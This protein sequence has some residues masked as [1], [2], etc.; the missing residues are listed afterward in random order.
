M[1]SIT[2]WLLGLNNVASVDSVDVSLSAPWARNNPFWL[3]LSLVVVVALA[4]VFYVRFQQRGALWQRV[5]LGTWRG[6]LLAVLL[7]TLAAPV[8]RLSQTTVQRPY[9][10]VVIDGTD[11]MAIEDELPETQRD[12]LLSA[13]GYQPAAQ[14]QAEDAGAP[15]S[16][17]DFVRQFLSRPSGNVLDRLQRDKQVRV[18][19]FLFDGQSTSQ[20]RKLERSA[21]DNEELEPAHLA[22]Q[23]SADG[24]V[25]AMG[26]V[27]ADIGRQF[28]A[29]NLA[30]VLVVSDFANNSGPAPVGLASGGQSPAGRLG[31]PVYTLGVGAREAIDLAIDLQTDPKMKKAERSNLTVK[32][33]Q[34]GLTDSQV[35]VRLVARPLSGE[36]LS[37]S[38]SLV[39]GEKSVTL[40]SPV[41]IVDFPFTP[42]DSGRFE[43][44]AEV[45]PVE[46][47]AVD[48]N[49]RAIRQVNI[50]DDYLRLM[51]IEEE[52]SWEWRFVKEVFHRDKLVGLDG[53]RT[54]L[55]SSDARVRESNVL[56]LPTLT[57]KRSQ[58]FANDV[59]FVG[60]M[61]GAMLSP[62]FCEMAK[63]FVGKF[64]GG[65]VVIAGPRFG[66]RELHA[67]ALADLLPVIVDP[68]A[69]LHDD[70]P[71]RMRLTPHAARYSFMHLG[72]N[73][74]ES[75]KAWDNL[76]E[77]QWY[78][79]VAQLHDQAYALAE[80]PTA[81]CH[82][83]KTPQP[84]IAI[85]PYGN[86]EV[87]YLGFNETWRLRRKYGDKYYRQFWS[88]LIYRLG[89]S[90]AL[91]SEKRFVVRTDRQQ[92]RAEERVT[93]TVEAYD[94]NFEPL[95]EE[96]LGQPALSA[97]LVVPAIGA[98]APQVRQVTVPLVRPGLFE[99]H[100]PVYAA[101]EYSLRVRDPVAGNDSEVRF[102]VSELSAERRVGVRDARLQEQLAAETHGR[103]YELTNVS[104]L[105]DD[106]QVEP[107]VETTRREHRLWATPAWFG[108]V[109]LLMLGEWFV[110]K[111]IK[112]P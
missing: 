49:N 45:D 107:W 112:L 95:S 43:F 90:H 1:G 35:H 15:R 46:G 27:V 66:P 9:F 3:F 65:L 31:V 102:E 97:E 44:V 75:D 103:S 53:F 19:T 23:L 111:M 86:G 51:F 18:E 96:Q 89:M 16:R 47:E 84:L 29:G 68:D 88:Q 80:H 14:G 81:L 63:E 74:A 73:D 76:G 110:R 55:A 13:V 70:Q 69:P 60:D 64:G 58:F 56:F 37:D 7:L 2:G 91:G 99:A 59:I 72:A 38:G 12:E 33:R 6:V 20:L 78:Q 30:G 93:L 52:P 82:D 108:L 104:R 21:G 34:S 28:G 26:S 25:T 62:R 11:S 109:V 48:Q 24:Q 67:T 98:G 50:I 79:S 22:E 54:Y 36:A 85:R 57:P 17:V 41:E 106:L 87:V 40:T 94:E 10:F 71:F 92:Y 83:G 61:P 105:L 39:V 8:L 5:V 4:I 32:V 100:L 42:K 101:G 77:L